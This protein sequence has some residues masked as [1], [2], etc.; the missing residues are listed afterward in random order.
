MSLVQLS[1]KHLHLE[2]S[3]SGINLLVK[4]HQSS[5]PGVTELWADCS[6]GD[7]DAQLKASLIKAS[8]ELSSVTAPVIVRIHEVNKG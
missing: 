2:V 4:T 5:E 6:H 7:E 1:Q 8:D 3:C